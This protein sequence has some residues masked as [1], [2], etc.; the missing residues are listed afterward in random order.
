MH[1]RR[2]LSSDVALQKRAL[3]RGKYKYKKYK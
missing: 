2:F 1:K 3:E